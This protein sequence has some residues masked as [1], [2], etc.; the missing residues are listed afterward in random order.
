MGIQGLLPLLHG[1]THDV[2]LNDGNF[3]GFVAVVDA[4]CWIHRAC[5]SC[6]HELFMG[7]TTD[8]FVYYCINRAETLINAGIKP[9]L[10][11]DG[12]NLPAKKLTEMKRQK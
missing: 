2:N 5:Y 6:G 10:V 3:E 4:Y 8:Q 9:I 7:H 12:Q 11:F 1:I